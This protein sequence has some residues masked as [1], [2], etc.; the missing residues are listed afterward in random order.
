MGS[1]VGWIWRCGELGY[2]EDPGFWRESVCVYRGRLL[3]IHRFSTV[4][5][6]NAPNPCFVDLL[7]SILNPF[8]W[9]KNV[10]INNWVV[11]SRFGNN[12]F[13]HFEHCCM[14]QIVLFWRLSQQF[15]F[16][17]AYRFSGSFLSV[18]KLTSFTSGTSCISLSIF[19][20]LSPLFPVI[21]LV[22]LWLKSWFGFGHHIFCLLCFFC[23][24]FW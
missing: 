13:L 19:S 2:M 21:F 5:R 11:K 9:Q 8:Y 16:L 6:V 22:F 17:I 18:D 1:T 14:L 4:Q 12:F 15:L 10:F 23:C 3:S 20:F 7:F 24:I